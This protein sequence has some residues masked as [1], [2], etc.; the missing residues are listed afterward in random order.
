MAFR[1]CKIGR[2]NARAV[3]PGD[4]LYSGRARDWSRPP[5]DYERR[6]T[7]IEIYDS[8]YHHTSL[9]QF[10][11]AY[12]AQ[13]LATFTGSKLSLQGDIPEWTM[14]A[15]ETAALVSF[16]RKQVAQQ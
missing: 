15:D 4:G 1:V 3:D 8:R 9:G 6:D 12:G 2:F 14:T 10:V 13:T 11:S 7:I 16:A 5:S